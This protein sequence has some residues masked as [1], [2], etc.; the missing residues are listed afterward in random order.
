MGPLKAFKLY[1]QFRKLGNLLDKIKTEDLKMK[2]WKTWAGAI[3]IGGS[4][5]ATF[6]GYREIGDLMVAIGTSVGIIGIGHK[7]EKAS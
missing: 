6:L 2:G 7:I 1:L 5:V 3:L 4:A